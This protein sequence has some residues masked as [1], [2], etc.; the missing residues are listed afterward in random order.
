[1]ELN[2]QAEKF[3]QAWGSLG[4]N[5]GI[6]KT[7]AQI[8][9]LLLISENALS[10]EDIMEKLKISRGNTNMNLRALM[11]WGLIQ[12]E[13]IT[14][15]RRE[16]FMA[17]KDIWKVSRLIARERRKRELEPALRLLE[18]IRAVKDT[19]ASTKKFKKQ[20][21][22]VYKFTAMVDSILEKFIKSNN[23]WMMKIFSYIAK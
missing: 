15:E 12:K 9:A 10:T 11:D 21:E 4:S 14:G 19:D 5:W 1:M 18:E 8:H 3:Y 23:S 13:H 2:Q 17:E 7:M 22:E 6:N 16:Y 20:I